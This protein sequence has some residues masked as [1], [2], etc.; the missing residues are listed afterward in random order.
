VARTVAAWDLPD[1]QALALPQLLPELAATLAIVDRAFFVDACAARDSVAH[2]APALTAIAPPD[3]ANSAATMAH[4]SDPL[5]LLAL[6]QAVY[7]RCPEAWLLTIPGK[8]FA[9]GASLSPLAIQ[10]VQNALEQIRF[11]VTPDA[12]YTASDPLG[13]DRKDVRTDHGPPSDAVDAR[14]SHPSPACG[15]G[16]GGEGQTAHPNASNIE[17]AHLFCPSLNSDPQ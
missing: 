13:T 6:T 17:F 11:L 14:L 9:L 7:G 8:D 3:L 10:G 1:V 2:A 16:A 5:A 4:I 12:V 15:R